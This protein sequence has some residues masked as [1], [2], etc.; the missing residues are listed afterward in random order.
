MCVLEL[1]LRLRMNQQGLQRGFDELSQWL[2]VIRSCDQ[3]HKATELQG[4]LAGGREM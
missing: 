2:H 1:A 3:Q 4:P